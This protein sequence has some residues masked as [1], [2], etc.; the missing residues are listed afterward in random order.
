MNP[1]TRDP[2]SLLS[3]VATAEALTE[4]GYLIKPKTLATM[5]TR[6]GGPP[7]RKW[8][9][10]ALYRWEDA[11]RW[12]QARL[13]APQ[14]NTSAQDVR[15]QSLATSQKPGSVPDGGLRPRRRTP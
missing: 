15:A 1:L 8:S 12:A 2:N 11:L 9:K 13:T 7:Y 14:P 4:A 10:V 3:R 6:G 5:A